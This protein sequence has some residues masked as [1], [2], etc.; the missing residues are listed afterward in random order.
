MDWSLQRESEDGPYSR[1][2]DVVV[3]RYGTIRIDGRTGMSL[4]FPV[5]CSERV[6]GAPSTLV[7]CP[8]R[9]AITNSVDRLHHQ[10]NGLG[11]S[12]RF[13]LLSSLSS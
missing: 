10:G 4:T 1:A 9:R 3:V 8:W 2:L 11:A 13:A 5:I 6:D 7:P 12:P